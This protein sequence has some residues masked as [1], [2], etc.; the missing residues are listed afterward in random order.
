LLGYDRRFDS[1]GFDLQLDKNLPAIVAVNDQLTQVFMNLLINAMDACSSLDQGMHN[2]VLK[3]ELDGDRVHIS[4]R[5][6]GCGMSKQI[7]E[8]ARDVFYTTKAVGLG[9]GLGLSLCDTI[10]SAHGGEF[11][12]ES[13]EGKGTLVHV[14]LPVDL[15]EEEIDKIDPA[16]KKGDAD[17]LEYSS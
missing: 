4:V 11:V 10:V 17:G 13:E 3:T 14:Y 9:T 6:F 8:Q 12:I 7:L 2:I 15:A 16:I 5:D 1:I